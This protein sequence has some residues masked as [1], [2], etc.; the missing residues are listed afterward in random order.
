MTPTGTLR[1]GDLRAS[2]SGADGE[3]VETMSTIERYIFRNGLLVFVAALFVLTATIWVTQALREVDLLTT[4]GQTL[5]VFLTLTLLTLPTL[6]MVLAP[7]ALF[8]AVA[9][10]LNRMNSD[11]ELVV[12]SSAGL[13]PARLL[14]PFMA[15]SCIV[16]VLT[17]LVSLWIM[18]SSWRSIRDLVSNIRTDVLTR[19]VREGQFISLEQGFVFHY[20]ERGAGGALLGI[21]IQD[22]R[23]IDRITTYIAERG[24]TVEEG[25]RNFLVLESGSI[26]RQARNDL[27]PA[28]V[29]F[30][31]YAIDLAQFS[32]QGGTPYKPREMLTSELFALDLDQPFFRAHAG[33]F[34]AELHDRFA[35]PFYSL[36]FALIAF[37]ALGQ[38]RTTRQGRGAAIAAAVVAVAAVRMAGFGATAIAGTRQWALPLIYLAPLGACALALLAILR[39]GWTARWW[40]RLRRAT[41]ITGRRADKREARP[42]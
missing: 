26:Q 38:P 37:A 24:I 12:M 32:P 23:D 11:S 39:P 18:P 33:R 2:D 41:A 8:I 35:A 29:Q 13:S 6:V 31:S 22:R 19:I 17:M 14:R 20:R 1:A 27:D 7:V 34:R 9:Y 4:Q 15:L 10:V 25:D 5:I 16:L 21:F 36:A 42:A 28:V 40:A 3:T 30:A